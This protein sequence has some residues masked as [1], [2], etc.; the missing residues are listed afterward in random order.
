MWR[1]LCQTIFFKWLGWQA[2]VTVRPCDKRVICVAPHTS[3]WDF[4]LA[5]LYYTAIGRHAYFLMKKEW[6]FWPLNYLW[7][8]MG[9][10]PVDRGSKNS[11][12]DQLAEKAKNSEH[13]EL[14]VTPEGT[15][16]RNTNW[17]MGFY[18][19]ALKAQLPIHLY[20]ID[21]RRRSI[22][23]TREII[24]SGH[25]EADMATIKSYYKDFTGRHPGKFAI[26]D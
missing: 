13:F 19:I 10:I 21:Y 26:S 24:P 8:K 11:L 18:F 23:C 14:A 6:F 16:S 1:K 5:E 22:I 2:E 20:A 12:T 4:I 17:K 25:I 3:N 9:G 7:T 15:R